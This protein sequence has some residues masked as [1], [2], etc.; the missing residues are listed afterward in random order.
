MSSTIRAPYAELGPGGDYPVEVNYAVRIYNTPPLNEKVPEVGEES[1]S[2]KG[3]QRTNFHGPVPVL[4]GNKK[5]IGWAELTRIVSARPEFMPLSEVQA[6]GFA[7][8]E[9]A[10]EYAKREHG[11]EFD[12]DG[13]IT[14][15]HYKVIRLEPSNT[16]AGGK[17]EI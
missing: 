11:D 1:A 15:F 14:V 2:L 8:M 5:E 3:G 4:D 16:Q 9:S 17:R 6:C 10:V 13:V 7:T 12:R